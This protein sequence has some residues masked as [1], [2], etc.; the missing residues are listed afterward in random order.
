MAEKKQNNKSTDEKGLEN[1]ARVLRNQNISLRKLIEEMDQADKN[2][3][4]KNRYKGKE[5]N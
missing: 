2:N 3:H 4:K 5:S 1:L